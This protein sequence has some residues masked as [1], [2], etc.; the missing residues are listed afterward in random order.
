[1]RQES[2]RP[3]LRDLKSIL[4]ERPTALAPFL[5]EAHSAD[6]ADWLEHVS[7]ED[8]WRTFQALPADRRA[9]VLDE[10][11]DTL[12]ADLLRYMDAGE[13]VELVQE[14]PLDEAVDLLELTDDRTTEAVLGNVEL[15]HAQELRKLAAYPSETAGG[16][17]TSE[18]VTVRPEERIGDAIKLVRSSED[19]AYE[20]GAGVYVVDAAGRLAGFVSDHDLL[21]TPIHTPV[22]DVME[23]DL[24]TVS[25]ED[26]RE[27][28]ARLASKYSLIAV[29]VVDAGERLVGVLNADDLREVVEVEATEDMVRMAGA[30]EAHQTRL[31]VIK[32]VRSRIP[33]MAVT[34]LGGLV[35]AYIL[36]KFATGSG[37]GNGSTTDLLR[38]LPIVIGLAGNVGI[39]SSTILVRGFATGE[40]ERDRELSILGSEVVVGLVI[41]VLCGAVTAV[42]AQG[43]ETQ[44][45]SPALFG[46]AVG[47]AIL[48]A[49]TWASLLGCVIPMSCRRLGIDPAIVAGPF[50]ITLSDISGAAI[51]MLVA[52]GILVSV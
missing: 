26:D 44:M 19:E 18:F 49:V 50:L 21:T 45:S 2:E 31:P 47:L 9:E 6:I 28:A 32:R 12:R 13:I 8:A 37:A 36:D 42:V 40:V 10:A 1:M 30:S 4:E 15:D 48:I 3:G 20:E 34:V 7:E 23:T 11:E 51:F 41:G 46:G 22:A 17:M 25:V 24:A 5:A 39:Q 29:P 43:M 14:L 38:Y 16:E 52:H 35:T 33:L 27:E